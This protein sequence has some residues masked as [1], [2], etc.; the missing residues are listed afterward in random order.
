MVRFIADPIETLREII[1]IMSDPNYQPITGPISIIPSIEEGKKI[2]TNRGTKPVDGKLPTFKVRTGSGGSRGARG[3]VELA[4]IMQVLTNDP[5]IVMTPDMVEI[6]ND[7][8]I[9]MDDNGGIT[10]SPSGLDVIRGSGQ[11]SRQGLLPRF[12]QPK[13][14]KRKVSKYQKEFG[15]QLKKLKAKHPRT[16]ITRLMKRAHTATR[17]A[18]K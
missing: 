4:E 1:D 18:M 11:F 15:K 13:K 6:I 10:R 16:K 5:D 7:P 3:D 17:K 2:R 14:K 8:G 12:E 9:M